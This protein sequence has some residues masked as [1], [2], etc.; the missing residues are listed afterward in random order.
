MGRPTQ[1]IRGAG[2]LILPFVILTACDDGAEQLFGGGDAQGF[3]VAYD[4]WQPG[5]DDSCT[6]EIHNSYSVVGPDGLVY[7]TWHPP[8]DAASGC[9]FG[10]EHGRDPRGS[11]LYKEVGDI[12]FGY[13]LPADHVGY[14]IE[15]ENDIDFRFDGSAA[16]SL[17]SVRCD[18][19]VE[20]H[21]GSHGAGAFRINTHELV[22]HADCSDGTELHITLISAIGD[23]GSFVA[24][25]DRDRTIV[26]GP[27]PEGAPDGGG[28][29]L[30][31]DRQ[32][33]EEFLLVPDGERS[34]FNSGVRESWQV[35]DRIKTEEGKTLV[36]FNPYFQV[37]F[38][39]RYY[40][41]SAPNGLARTIDAC[42]EVEPNGERANGGACEESTAEGSITSLAFDD[43]RSAFNGANR[44]VD[45]NSIRISNADGPRV[46]YTDKFGKHART[47]PFEGS[48]RQIIATIDN[49]RADDP[50]GPA[51]GRKRDYGEGQAV[52]AP[53]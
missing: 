28:V 19:L 47:E 35:S 36:S 51:I 31:P 20:L 24:S 1:F 6:R 43:L 16:S 3:S 2:S 4:K 52:H 27:P 11:N 41:P 53:N 45:V 42:F 15:W 33:I 49:D 22:Y 5:L 12:P 18:V 25:C 21:Q 26:A 39:A 40:D 38:P 23:P 7:P 46:W 48:I 9:T 50:S 10:H 14:K 17:L 32:C 29:R 44:F 13:A 37:L 34:N 30:I 8:M